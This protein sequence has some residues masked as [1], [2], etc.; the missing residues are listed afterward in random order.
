MYSGFNLIDE[1]QDLRKT[2]RIRN[3]IDIFQL[4]SLTELLIAFTDSFLN[5]FSFNTAKQLSQQILIFI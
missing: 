3:K 4:R 5:V 2:N 1:K